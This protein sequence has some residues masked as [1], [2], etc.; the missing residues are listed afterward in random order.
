MCHKS[1]YYEREISVMSVDYDFH[2]F[3]Q[4]NDPKAI[5]QII[6][7]SDRLRAI[8]NQAHSLVT[9]QQFLSNRLPMF[10]KIH[11]Q[12]AHCDRSVLTIHVADAVAVT[13]LQYEAPQILIALRALPLCTHLKKITWKVSPHVWQT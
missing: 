9:I 1:T 13:R 5:H 3:H 12:V 7:E 2:Y 10:Q 11:Y 8:V 6:H 4:S